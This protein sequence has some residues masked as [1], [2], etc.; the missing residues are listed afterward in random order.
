MPRLHMQQPQCSRHQHILLDGSWVHRHPTH[1]PDGPEHPN[2]PVSVASML[3][4]CLCTKATE[5][6]LFFTVA[7]Q[8]GWELNLDTKLLEVSLCLA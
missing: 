7:S 4:T 6:R 5:L 3:H 8:E 2:V 1:L